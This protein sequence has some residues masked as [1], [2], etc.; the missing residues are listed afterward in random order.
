MIRGEAHRCMT[1]GRRIVVLGSAGT[2]QLR[3]EVDRVVL[4]TGFRGGI[5]SEELFS[6]LAESLQLPRASDGY[7]IVDQSL[8]WTD[9]L[10]L[11]GAPAELELGPPAR[12][13]IGA[14]LAGRRIV[15]SILRCLE[16]QN[17]S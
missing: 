16:G 7:P 1:A 13:I 14:H 3:Y 8:S 15:P 17:R 5:P 12:N 4:A 9:R 11:S 6:H 2:R 10:F